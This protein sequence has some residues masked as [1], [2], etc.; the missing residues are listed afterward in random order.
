MYTL[1]YQPQ[2]NLGAVGLEGFGYV[3]GAIMLVGA[4]V[5]GYAAYRYSKRGGRKA[6]P[7]VVIGGAL[8]FPVGFQLYAL[9]IGRWRAAAR[10]EEEQRCAAQYCAQYPD[11]CDQGRD[12]TWYVDGNYRGHSRC[13]QN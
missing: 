12:G 2:R 11:R 9:T 10:G 8:A 6:K 5:G 3:L 7:G 1:N 4:G 13:F